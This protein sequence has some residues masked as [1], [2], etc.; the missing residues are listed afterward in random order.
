MCEG[1]RAR[2]VASSCPL[3]EAK[4]TFPRIPFSVWFGG[5]GAEGNSSP[6]PGRQTRGSPCS[7]RV[8]RVGGGGELRARSGG[9]GVCRPA[10][11]A[12]PPEQ[13]LQ[14]VHQPSR[15]GGDA[16]AAASRDLPGPGC[17]ICRS[18]RKRETHSPWF[19]QQEQ[20]AGE[21]AK[22]RGLPS[23]PRPLSP[24]SR[25]LLIAL[26]AVRLLT[27]RRRQHGG[28]VFPCPPRSF[29]GHAVGSRRAGTGVR[30]VELGLLGLGAS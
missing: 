18:R 24:G 30:E 8:F 15:R 5:E 17:W 19:T 28:R 2:G 6:R 1:E 23:L 9:R 10:V 22:T 12:A 14:V 7:V 20:S 11:P 25:P 29:S 26:T 13:R 16:E 27:V 3:G 4:T 21:G